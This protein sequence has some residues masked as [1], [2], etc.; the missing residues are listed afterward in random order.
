M[1][2]EVAR[3]CRQRPFMLYAA[4]PSGSFRLDVDPLADLDVRNRQER[5]V[6]A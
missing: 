3:A 5:F 6:F 2:V 4:G 1:L